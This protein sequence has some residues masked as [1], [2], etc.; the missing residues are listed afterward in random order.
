VHSDQV[1][2]SYYKSN[3]EEQCRKRSFR[4]TDSYT[5]ITVVTD[6]AEAAAAAAATAAP[7]MYTSDENN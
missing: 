6:Y 5:V 2:L 7:I 3:K 4:V 1:E